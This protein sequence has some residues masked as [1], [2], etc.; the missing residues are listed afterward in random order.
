YAV[1]GVTNDASSAEIRSSYKKLMLQCHPD[2]VH[3]ATLRAEKA[4]MFEKVQQAY[5]LLA[6]ARKRRKYD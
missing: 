3:D 4:E 1:L 5:E 2:K 6:D